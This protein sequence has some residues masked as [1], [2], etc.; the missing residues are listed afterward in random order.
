MKRSEMIKKII[1]QF[2]GLVDSQKDS[3]QYAFAY[4][5]ADKLLNFIEEQGMLP[6]PLENEVSNIYDDTIYLRCIYPRLFNGDDI[7]YWEPEN[8]KFGEE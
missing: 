8:D 4:N 5:E 2:N 7:I 1:L 3:P 6:P